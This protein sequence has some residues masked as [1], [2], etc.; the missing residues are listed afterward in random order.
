MKGNLLE[1]YSK[2]INIAEK[3][4]AGRHAGEQLSDQ[5]KLVTAVC[6]NNTNKFLTEAF[7]NSVGT[8]MADMGASYHPFKQQCLNKFIQT[9]P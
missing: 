6:L 4:Y 2:R 9:I 3:F 7:S 8:Q 1:A 5:K